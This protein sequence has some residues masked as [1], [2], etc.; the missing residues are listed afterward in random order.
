MRA[1]LVLLLVLSILSVA[2]GDESKKDTSTKVTGTITF[3]SDHPAANKLKFQILL[4]EYDPQLADVSATLIEKVEFKDF[5]H[6]AG[7]VT[8]KKFEI[9]AKGK[10]NEQK[11]Y[12]LASFL[13][14]G[15][16]RVSMGELDN[17][18]GGIGKVLTKGQPREVKITAKPVQ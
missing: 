7:K 15:D 6:A 16:N 4:Y 13:L 2:V 14:D 17:D 5:T 3:P 10:L 11:G 12:Y 8:E 1:S 9:G 18:K